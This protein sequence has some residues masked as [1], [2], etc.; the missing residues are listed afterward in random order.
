MANNKATQKN[1]ISLWVAKMSLG[2]FFLAI[3]FGWV[4]QLMLEE[5]KV[6]YFSIF[7][8]LF[9]VFV[10]VLFDTIGTAAAAADE[11]PLNSKATRKIYGAQKGVSLVRRADQV[12]NFCNDVIG[13]ITGILSGAVAA[14]LVVQLAVNTPEL[15]F[16]VRILITALVTAL[17]V[18]GKAWGK[19]LALN[20]ST[21]IMLMVGRILTTTDMAIKRTNKK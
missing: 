18:G 6:I 19:Y 16:Y 9:I 3:I 2:T 11:A 21:E 5:I 7:L 20:Y 10:G 15:N 14:L 1:N 17:T 4:S 12:A 8:L 13:D